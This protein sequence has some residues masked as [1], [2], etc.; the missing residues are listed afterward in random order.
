MIEAWSRK[1]ASGWPPPSRPSSQPPGRQ[2][3]AP[4][5]SAHAATTRTSAANAFGA[6]RAAL[7]ARPPAAEMA[8]T[9]IRS[10]P[11]ERARTMAA[12]RGGSTTPSARLELA[13]DFV[14][15]LALRAL[16]PLLGGLRLR[17]ARLCRIA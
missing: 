11:P 8:A 3:R 2:G 12:S 5:R 15:R 17:V 7:A 10:T 4:P 16:R 1:D 14:E 9:A 6:P 13:H